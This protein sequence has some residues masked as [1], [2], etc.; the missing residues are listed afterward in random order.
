ME[1]IKINTGLTTEAFE[2]L[3]FEYHKK[4][5]QIICISR[6]PAIRLLWNLLSAQVIISAE[7][8]KQKNNPHF[9]GLLSAHFEHSSYSRDGFFGCLF[10]YLHLGTFI[11][12]TVIYFLK[13]IH[14]HILAFITAASYTLRHFRWNRN[15]LFIR[16]STLHL[17]Q[18][19]AFRSDYKAFGSYRMVCSSRALVEPITSLCAKIGALHSGWASTSTPGFSF[20]SCNKA[21]NENRLCT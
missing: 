7:R 14:P 8:S 1:I 16:T 6:L 12:E 21:S 17:K 9:S 11:Q 5:H 18:N 19:T 13:R 15:K 20:F 4:I 10:F 3:F 2:Q